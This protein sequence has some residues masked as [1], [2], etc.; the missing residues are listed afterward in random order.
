MR[1]YE[2]NESLRKPSLE[3]FLNGVVKNQYVSFKSSKG[4]MIS[5]YVRKGPRYIKG[6]KYPKVLDRA[7][8]SLAASKYQRQMMKTGTLMAGTG[9]YREFDVHMTDLAKKYGY[10]GIYVE[11]VL[12]EGFF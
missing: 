3:E 6:V 12:N 10:D 2:L 8:T 9:A 4:V 5:S 1:A 7:N 11:N